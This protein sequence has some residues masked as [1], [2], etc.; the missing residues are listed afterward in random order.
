VFGVSVAQGGGD[1]DS[2]NK[3]LHGNL[4]AV[5]GDLTR[6]GLGV[7]P[8]CSKGITAD[9]IAGR[10]Q[11]AHDANIQEIDIWADVAPDDPDSKLWCKCM[12]VCAGCST[13]RRIVG[14]SI[15]VNVLG[16][17]VFAC[18]GAALRKWKSMPLP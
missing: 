3:T 4:D 16:M 6:Y 1:N 7:C 5:G 8:G 11:L 17:V 9:Q 12:V 2:F 18:A 13:R 14:R 15:V 10:L